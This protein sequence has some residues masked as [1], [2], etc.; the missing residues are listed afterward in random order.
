MIHGTS[1]AEVSN[2]TFV[3]R[4][5][6]VRLDS[7]RRPTLPGELLDLLG[8]GSG[9]VLI[10]SINEDRI[11]VLETPAQVRGRLRQAFGSSGTRP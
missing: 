1:E 2:D 10:A 9:D 11:L 8:V 7:R 3:G 5:F 6:P 4:K